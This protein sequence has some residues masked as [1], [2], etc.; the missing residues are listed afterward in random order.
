MRY[1]VINTESI[2][3]CYDTKLCGNEKGLAIKNR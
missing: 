1:E 3:Y 2:L